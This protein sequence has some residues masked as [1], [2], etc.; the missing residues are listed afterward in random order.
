MEG[1][2]GLILVLFHGGG[3]GCVCED[4]VSVLVHTRPD[5]DPL[6]SC[7]RH[8]WALSGIWAQG[9]A[10]IWADLL[11]GRCWVC[12]LC[13][14]KGAKEAKVIFAEHTATCC[15]HF[16]TSLITGS[17]NINY[18]GQWARSRMGDFGG[19]KGPVHVL[20]LS[21][22]MTL[23]RDAPSPD[24]ISTRCLSL[25]SSESLYQGPILLFQE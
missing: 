12:F 22:P 2:T 11:W 15:S 1:P 4:N 21:F 6:Q 16:L 7:W 18:P 10:R 25:Q 20:H 5:Q 13:R 23:T 14:K 17:R 19:T 9:P 8:P 3:W 24:H